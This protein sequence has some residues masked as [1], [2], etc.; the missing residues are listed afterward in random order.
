[1][2]ESIKDLEKLYQESVTYSQQLIENDKLQHQDNDEVSVITTMRSKEGMMSVLNPFVSKLI[3]G[4]IEAVKNTQHA[5]D[6]V[7]DLFGD[8]PKPFKYLTQEE[9]IADGKR[10]E[11]IY[12]RY[13]DL[14]ASY[15]RA[16]RIRDFSHNN[17]DYYF[18]EYV[19]YKVGVEVYDLKTGKLLE[20]EVLKSFM[21]NI[22]Q[23]PGS[24]LKLRQDNRSPRTVNFDAR[25]L[26]RRSDFSIN[27][28]PNRMK[29]EAAYNSAE[30]A[31]MSGYNKTE[32]PS[33]DSIR[34]A[35]DV[36]LYYIRQLEEQLTKIMKEKDLDL[37]DAFKE[38][39][40]N[41][42]MAHVRQVK[43]IKQVVSEKGDTV[44]FI[45]FDVPVVIRRGEKLNEVEV[46]NGI[47]VPYGEQANVTR[48]NGVDYI[49]VYGG[50]YY[51]YLSLYQSLDYFLHDLTRF[52]SNDYKYVRTG[53]EVKSAFAPI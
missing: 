30:K 27:D 3:S 6:K 18:M 8:K 9:L 13:R 53:T 21:E 16:L 5:I 31:F 25:L 50:Q 45:E 23:L 46:Y 44:K 26:P 35:Y 38:V 20:K 33:F 1:M 10:A 2:K 43:A 28:Y 49:T 12:G 14:K 7:K 36:R 51:N 37:G 52:A 17:Q 15:E 29:L 40:R 48:Y 32:F 47:V 22:H 11:D 24:K 19:N 42:E 41:S 39:M 4:G 34:T